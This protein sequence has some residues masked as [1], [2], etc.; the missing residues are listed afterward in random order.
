MFSI[1]MLSLSLFLCKTISTMAAPLE[2]YFLTFNCG[3]ALI[4]SSLF[5]SHF[6]QALPKTQTQLPDVISISLQEVGPPLFLL[7]KSREKYDN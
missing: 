4:D 5:A 3:R 7:H 2:I 1:R 6:F